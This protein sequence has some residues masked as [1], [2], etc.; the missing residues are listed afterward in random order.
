MNQIRMKKMTRTIELKVLIHL[1]ED[2][3][4]DDQIVRDV[5]QA[6]IDGELHS[7][8]DNVELIEFSTEDEGV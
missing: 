7:L 1:Q 5:V 2:I 3:P 6:V 8:V 4:G